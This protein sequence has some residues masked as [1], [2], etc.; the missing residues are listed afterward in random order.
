[1]S[2]RY[3]F[4]ALGVSLLITWSLPS[5]LVGLILA[6]LIYIHPY[7]SLAFMYLDTWAQAHTLGLSSPLQLQSP[8]HSNSPPPAHLDAYFCTH[9]TKAGTRCRI[10]P[11]PQGWC[12]RH[13]P[14]P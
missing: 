1:M 9:V 5:T 10:P 3:K 14:T 8:N 6:W 4:Y 13:R 12:K 11:G 7:S 2:D